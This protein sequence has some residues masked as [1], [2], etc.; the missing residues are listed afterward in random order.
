MEKQIPLR[1]LSMSRTKRKSR[2]C[3]STACETCRAKKAKCSG[4]KP[5][6]RCQ[7]R[8]LDCKYETR[9]SRTKH[10]LRLE[11]EELKEAKRQ[12][13]ALIRELTTPVEISDVPDCLWEG[14]TLNDVDETLQDQH[15]LHYPTCSQ[16]QN[17]SLEPHQRN[18]EC[19]C[20]NTINKTEQNHVQKSYDGQSPIPPSKQLQ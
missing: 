15:S 18:L 4:G 19:S 1:P 16:V 12:R 8:G 7:S 20:P 10:S 2:V 11:I 5:C 6:S 17:H 13:E 9:S 14:H 3:I